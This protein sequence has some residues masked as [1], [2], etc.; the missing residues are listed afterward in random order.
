[1]QKFFFSETTWTRIVLVN[2]QVAKNSRG[3][4]WGQITA[5]RSEVTLNGDKDYTDE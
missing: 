1:M 5:R 4:I 3:K 2:W